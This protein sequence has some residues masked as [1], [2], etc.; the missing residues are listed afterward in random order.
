MM[1]K[2][3]HLC[4]LQKQTLQT[5][6]T[7]EMYW[8]KM[9]SG[10]FCKPQVCIAANYFLQNMLKSAREVVKYRLMIA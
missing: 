6:R 8:A 1:D 3:T 5:N 10:A 2:K 9:S 4:K 7:W